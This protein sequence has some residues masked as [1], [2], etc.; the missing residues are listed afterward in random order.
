MLSRLSALAE[1]SECLAASRGRGL[2][3]GVDVVAN[4]GSPDPERLDRILEELKDRG[5]LWGKT[6]ADRNVLTLMPPL[7]VEQS[8]LEMALDALSGVLRDT[9]AT[10]QLR[11]P[12]A[13]GENAPPSRWLLNG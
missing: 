7:V 8:D 10:S 5:F 12:R 3:I 6:G 1:A 2:M 9:G 4:D 13:A 11:T